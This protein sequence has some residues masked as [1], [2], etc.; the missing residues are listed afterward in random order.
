[1]SE[2]N[3][4]DIRRS[5]DQIVRLLQTINTN[6]LALHEQALKGVSAVTKELTRD[7]DLDKLVE[8]SKKIAEAGKIFE[9][10]QAGGEIPKKKWWV[11]QRVVVSDQSSAL[12]GYQGEIVTIMG[13]YAIGVLLDDRGTEAKSFHVNH[14]MPV[15]PEIKLPSYNVVKDA[16]EIELPAVVEYVTDTNGCLFPW[17]WRH[18]LGMDKLPEEVRL[19]HQ[20]HENHP[21]TEEA[22]RIYNAGLVAEFVVKTKQEEQK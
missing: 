3:L 9:H 8:D 6:I 21:M 4:S 14:L 7:I 5:N 1:M 20:P 12:V 19:Q 17:Q 10:Y 13:Q 22:F 15:P 2:R 11:G 16:N 18:N